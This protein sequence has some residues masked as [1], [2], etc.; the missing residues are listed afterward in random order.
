MR[1]ALTTFAL[2]AFA[3]ATLPAQGPEDMA[4]A[5]EEANRVF[6]E[7]LTATKAFVGDVTFAEEDMQSLIEHWRALSELDIGGDQQGPTDYGEI[8]NDPRYQSFAAENG[9][10]AEPWLKKTSRIMVM[11]VGE[12]MRAQLALADG[13]IPQQGQMVEQQCAQPEASEETCSQMRQ[14][15][16]FGVEMLG[17]QREAW[18]SLPE[19]TEGE[20]A[21]LQQYEAQLTE[22]MMG[23]AEEQQQ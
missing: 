3:A 20:A 5:Y 22:L 18:N 16:E 23:P 12:R 1:R 2:L 14:Q 8:L 6:N 15:L 19:P 17:R 9:L 21:L 7:W 10:P 11:N 13:Q 4:A